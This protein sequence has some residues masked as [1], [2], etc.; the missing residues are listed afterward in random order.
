LS[1]G[2]PR[3]SGSER[4]EQHRAIGPERQPVRAEE[5]HIRRDR[6]QLLLGGACQGQHH[7]H[8][9]E[10]TM[11]F[12]GLAEQHPSLAPTLKRL[13]KQHERITVLLEE[14]KQA[15]SGADPLKVRAEI[16]RLVDELEAH[17]TY[18]E[19]Q[20]IPVLDLA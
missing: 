17:L 7:H 1:C 10:D 19:E 4:R 2:W 16:E 9:G 8:T 11:M 6:P 15:L 13:A 18:E 3:W 20:L 12:P 14:L 5:N